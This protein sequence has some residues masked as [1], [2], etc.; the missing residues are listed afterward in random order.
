M[1]GFSK[2]VIGIDIG[3]SALRVACI[4]VEPPGRPVVDGYAEKALPEGIL[5]PSYM[6]ENILDMKKFAE[7][8][9]HTLS[10]AGAG[11]AAIALSIPDQVVKVSFMDLKG[12]PRKRDDIL[13]FIKWKSRRFLPYD[14]ETAK[15]DYQMMG[16]GDI[17]MTVFVNAAVVSNYE[18]ALRGLSLRAR[19]VSTPSMSLYNLFSGRFGNLR[20]FAFISAGEDS[21]AV[22]I[23]KGGVLD[24]FRTTDTGLSDERLMQE[25]AS[26]ILFYV[27]ENQDAG[28]E[29]IFLHS[30]SAENEALKPGLSEAIG[31]DIN[32]LKLSEAV[33]V[34]KGLYLESY[35]AAVGAAL[36]IL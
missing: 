7:A 4:R 26:T 14:P 5:H 35:C 2:R 17:A 20:Q 24:F 6:K 21:F 1:F 33:E 27:S 19:T 29:K 32:S 8:L 9:R 11:R 31:H 36:S 30:A 22:M 28:I 18:E 25:I 12:V 13:N 3:T 15:I 34:P 23:I 10:A 16:E